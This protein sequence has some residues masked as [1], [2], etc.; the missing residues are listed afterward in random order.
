[1]KA[2]IPFLIIIIAV[3][4]LWFEAVQKVSGAMDDIHGILDLDL[5]RESF[6]PQPRVEFRPNRIPETPTTLL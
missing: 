3:L 1:M 2:L 5:I 4:A 6:A